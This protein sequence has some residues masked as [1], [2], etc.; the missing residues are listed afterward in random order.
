MLL[1]S[2]RATLSARSIS[3]SSLFLQLT[4]TKSRTFSP[5]SWNTFLRSQSYLVLS[6]Y[7]MVLG[8]PLPLVTSTLLPLSSFFHLALACLAVGGVY[9]LA[10]R[11]LGLDQ[12]D[13]VMIAALRVRL[14][15]N[16]SNT[17]D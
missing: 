5:R 15:P 3:R 6:R 10:L 7:P 2:E 14:M 1:T 8:L 13:R 17:A 16:A 9:L 12:G 11:L 4:V